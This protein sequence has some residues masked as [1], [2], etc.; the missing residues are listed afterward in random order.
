MREFIR[1]IILGLLWSASFGALAQDSAVFEEHIETAQ[2]AMFGDPNKALNHAII[3][4]AA[5]EPES[6]GF[7]RALWLQG[8]AQI[9]LGRLEAGLETLRHAETALAGRD[10]LLQA[11]TKMSGARALAM[12]QDNGGAMQALRRAHSL[13]E[14]AGDERGQALA[15]NGIAIIYHGAR[16]YER[17]LSYYR[18]AARYDQDPN[19][20]YS[21]NHNRAGILNELGR[22]AEARTIFEQNLQTAE[23]TGM[24]VMIATAHTVLAKNL[25][26]MG[27]LDRAERHLQ[28]ARQFDG[29]SNS[30]MWQDHLRL[31]RTKFAMARDREGEV[32]EHLEAVFDGYDFKAPK[33][34]ML[35]FHDLAFRFFRS[36]GDLEEAMRH[37]E[38]SAELEIEAADAAARNNVDLLTTEFEASQKDLEIERLKSVQLEGR[39]AAE[40]KEAELKQLLIAL[41]GLAAA[42]VAGL[43]GW[44]LLSARRA[45]KRLAGS[46]HDL[47]VALAAKSRFL[48]STSHEIRTPLNAIL[49]MGHV[50]LDEEKDPNRL[51]PIRTIVDAGE[52]L[53]GVVNDILDV[54]KMEKSGYEAN[55]AET[56]L[57]QAIQP[58]IDLHRTSAATK[59]LK[60][61]EVFEGDHFNFATDGRLLKQ[62]VGNL[63]SNAVKFTE[64]GEI[65]VLVRSLEGYGFEIEVADEGIG[66]PAQELDTIFESFRQVDGSA[67]RQYGGTGLGLTIVKHIAETLSGNVQVRSELGKGSLFTLSIPAAEVRNEPAGTGSAP[68]PEPRRQPERLCDLR[69]LVVEDNE[70]NQLVMTS[71]LA[72][73]VALFLVVGNGQEAVEA[74]KE[75]QF[76]VVLMDHHMPVMSGLEA[77][78]V[79]RTTEGLENLPIIGVTADVS[80][81]VQQTLLEA[82]MQ[83]V[84]NKPVKK[85]ALIDAMLEHVVGELE[86]DRRL[87]NATSRR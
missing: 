38:A 9:R 28:Q 72:K 60:L 79:I 43:C 25:I 57:T 87:G 73:E 15:L 65:T 27:L 78:R 16:R 5:A 71:M 80:A 19:L 68:I 47:E 13:F 61:T 7:A 24:P 17:A 67:T 76:D 55:I 6:V 75:R 77:T 42:S 26:D 70:V 58:V 30:P 52:L 10:K 33:P 18:Q 81:D 8:D 53:L 85:D 82:G 45:A 34:E 59:G 32:L 36:R 44:H 86:P 35:E 83:T 21:I 64:N 69:V 66:I 50:I 14:E 46:N 2:S 56:D 20:T 22:F 3:A 41:G 4:A 37:L 74:V 51:R 40:K 31:A 49:G 84:V 1:F 62:A 54:A 39:I 29:D 48:A 23:L 63:I 11:R 12:S